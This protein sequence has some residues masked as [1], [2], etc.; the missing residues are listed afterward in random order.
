MK[1]TTMS[2]P[3]LVEITG[4]MP[5]EERLFHHSTNKSTTPLTHTPLNAE[6]TFS[7]HYNYTF[8]LASVLSP[9]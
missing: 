4:D 1:D 3:N 6:C 2:S 7:D 8:K 5:Y 9:P